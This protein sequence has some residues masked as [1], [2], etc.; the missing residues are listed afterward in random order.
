M[1]FLLII[2]ST[3]IISVLSFT[4]IPL[5]K[6]EKQDDKHELLKRIGLGELGNN[7]DY[8]LKQFI[9]LLE[10]YTHET[11]SWPEIKIRNYM[12]S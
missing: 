9:P 6:Q 10:L 8:L 3:L 12:G 11:A 2:F 7:L 5:L 4:H 1:K